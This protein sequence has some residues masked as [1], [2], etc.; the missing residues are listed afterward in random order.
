MHY[1]FISY[2]GYNYIVR[3]FLRVII[4]FLWALSSI[5]FYAM[6]FCSVLHYSI[7][8]YSILHYSELSGNNTK[9]LPN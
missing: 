9:A 3:W 1:S 8:L 7:Q 6:P 4:I 2:V 5:L